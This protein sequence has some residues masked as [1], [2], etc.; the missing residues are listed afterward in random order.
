MSKS[1]PKEKK[2]LVDLIERLETG[3]QLLF[4]W[5]DI[6]DVELELDEPLGN[7]LGKFDY[8]SVNE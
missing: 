2:D 7:S 3:N 5:D 6:T 8:Y 1:K 4:E